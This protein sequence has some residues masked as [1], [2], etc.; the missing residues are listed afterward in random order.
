[1]DSA[2]KN[3]RYINLK[4]GLSPNY[5]L[6]NLTK[7][8]DHVAIVKNA[9]GTSKIC[10]Y[11]LKDLENEMGGEALCKT[12]E[13]DSKDKECTHIAYHYVNNTWY[14]VAGYVGIIEFYSED[15]SKRYFQGNSS[16]H[17]KHDFE[18]MNSVY[19][20]SC[21]GWSSTDSL[22]QD[23]FIMNGTSNQHEFIMV[24]TSLGEIY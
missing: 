4:H 18:L 7:S 20:C 17:S 11:K 8:D 12:I 19:L 3:F 10:V 2:K 1:M 23:E 21:V 13:W 16:D 9:F 14:L 5:L 6:N 24:G 22:K 15:G